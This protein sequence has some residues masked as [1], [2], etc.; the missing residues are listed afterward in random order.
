MNKIKRDDQVEVIA[1]RDKGGRGRVTKII[2]GWDGKPER[3]LVQGIGTVTHFDR[4]N[5][6]KN[7][8]G[9]L[10]KRE[11][12]IHV[13]NV[14]PLDPESGLRARVKMVTGEKGKERRFY[15]SPRRRPT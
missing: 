12:S 1:G 13:S 14:A 15:V 10:N 5:P 11:A 9:G 7:Q 2:R 8:P 3:V 6:Q 4:P